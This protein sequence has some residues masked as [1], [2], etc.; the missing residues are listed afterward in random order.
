MNK[1]KNIF[2]C[3]TEYHLFLSYHI[4]NTLYESSKYE[5]WIIMTTGMRKN[6][7]NYNKSALFSNTKMTEVDWYELRTHY[8]LS[9]LLKEHCNNFFYFLSHFPVHRYIVRNFSKNGTKII[10]VQDGLKP[11]APMEHFNLKSLLGIAY[12]NII[13]CIKIKDY[14]G[15]FELINTSKYVNDKHIN[16][17]WLSHPQAFHHHTNKS[18]SIIK[19]PEFSEQ[20]IKKLSIFYNYNL[21]IDFKPNDIL[22]LTMPYLSH[23]EKLIEIRFLKEVLS[24]YPQNK[25]YIKFHPS[26]SMDKDLFYKELPHTFLLENINFPAELIIQNMNKAIIISFCSTAQLLNNPKCRFYYIYPIVG[27]CPLCP[28]SNPN[29]MDHI[30]V[31]SKVDEL[32]FYD[33]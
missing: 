26:R 13:E 25:L 11:Y 32:Q 33:K 8:F 2:L 1:I 16:E 22:Y 6:V 12:Y 5:S 18:Q 19:I 20:S 9:S 30:K 4:I 3:T 28:I 7:C 29:F 21:Q 14:S 23:F 27:N 15:I 17:V 10:L 31:I 24:K